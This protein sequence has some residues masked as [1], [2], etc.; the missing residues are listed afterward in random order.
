[1][2]RIN[3]SPLVSPALT[4]RKSYTADDIIDQLEHDSGNKCYICEL[5]KLPDIN[6][7]HLHP[8]HG[9][10]DL[11]FD[12]NNLFLCCPH[13][14]SIK[15]RA[16]YEKDIIDC[17]LV[18]PEL[19]VDQRVNDDKITVSAR[20]D[21]Q[22]AR[23]TAALIE[24][25]FELRNHRI[26]KNGAD[27]RSEELRKTKLRLKMRLRAYS[28]PNQTDAKKE[29]HFAMLRGMLSRKAKFAGFLR[30]YIRDH[31]NEYPE[32]A[33]FVAL[34]SPGEKAETEYNRTEVSV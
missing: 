20:V 6:V 4:E 15:N 27:V 23:N 8:H 11:K 31:Q 13:C 32:L 24:D 21:T 33:S 19:L 16:V 26:R 18:D 10:P 12:W 28:A 34:E 29:R 1:M 17:C 14:N 9:D 30:T 25:C 3:R 2:V 22:E 7:E 5:A